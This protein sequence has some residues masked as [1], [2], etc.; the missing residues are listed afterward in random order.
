MKNKSSDTL[1]LRIPP[2]LKRQLAIDAAKGGTTIRSVILNALVA[3]GYEI[4]DN[5]IGD[6]RKD[7]S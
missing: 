1:Q 3:A 6:K 4:P 2:A 7:R 5:E